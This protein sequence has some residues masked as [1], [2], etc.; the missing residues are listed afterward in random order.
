[1]KTSILDCFGNWNIEAAR[2]KDFRRAD[3]I[4]GFSFG[5]RKNN[6]PGASNDK[7]ADIIAGVREHFNAPNDLPKNLPIMVQWEIAD[8]L[9]TRIPSI[10]V[11]G[12]NQIVRRHR[13]SG[14]YLDTYEVA[15]QIATEMF[16][17][18]LKNP[19]VVAAPLHMWRCLKAM[20]KFGFNPM[21][22]YTADVPY[23]E[24][25][26]QAR[27]RSPARYIPHEIAGRLISLKNGWI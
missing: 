21:P 18:S 1:M 22:A 24:L 23:D 14:K 26:I 20:E 25:S 10:L 15:T 13:Q 3:C 4:V 9:K 12:H 6:Q 2:E 19:V 27:T 17:Q 5:G 16:H 7:I 8:A 11:P